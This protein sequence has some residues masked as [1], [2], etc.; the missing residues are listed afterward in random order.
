MHSGCARIAKPDFPAEPV[1][2]TPH[3]RLGRLVRHRDR[4]LSRGQ[5][6]TRKKN[7]TAFPSGCRFTLLNRASF[8][9]PGTSA[10]HPV[11]PRLAVYRAVILVGFADRWGSTWAPIRSR[12]ASSVKPYFAAYSARQLSKQEIRLISSVPSFNLSPSGCGSS[13]PYQCGWLRPNFLNAIGD[14]LRCATGM[15]VVLDI[16]GRSFC[17]AQN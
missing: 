16:L 14:F 8:A 4:N 12:R 10:R 6:R 9:A 15:K 7:A 2:T 3:W 17:P 11:L 5:R 1:Q 13:L